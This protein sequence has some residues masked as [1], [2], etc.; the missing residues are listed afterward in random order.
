LVKVDG[1]N[2]H[3]KGGVFSLDGKRKFI[4]SETFKIASAKNLGVKIAKTLL[5]EGAS[6]LLEEFKP[7]E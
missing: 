4:A 5:L 2:I 7:S 3:F 1:E 6:T